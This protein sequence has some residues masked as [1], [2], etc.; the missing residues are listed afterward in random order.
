[1]VWA[2][3]HWESAV[4]YHSA[5]HPET[6][7]VCQDLH[8]ANWAKVPKHDLLLASPACQGHTP[9]RGKDRPHHD[10]TRATAWAVVS[11]AEF[12]KPAFIIVENVPKF[13]EWKLYPAWAFAMECLGYSISPHIL[14][15]ADFGVPQHRV[16]VFIILSKSRHPIKLKLEKRE[17]KPV[18]DCIEW[19]AHPWSPI[20]KRGRSAA[21]LQR[22][23]NARAEFGHTFVM[24]YYGSGSGETGRSLDRPLGTVTTRDRWALVDGDRMRMFSATEYRAVM[25]FP[26]TY[27]LP[28]QHKLAVHLLGNAVCPPVPEQIIPQL[29]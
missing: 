3:N 12:H 7:H 20:N 10:A 2:A 18:R 21:T 22:I 6:Q 26:S 16:R 24:P 11:C 9:A 14:D 15:A 13:L 29:N 25:G 23:A 8:Q 5:N 1:V 27:K 28:P 17:H 4:V 19:D